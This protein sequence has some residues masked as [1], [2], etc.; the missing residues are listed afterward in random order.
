MTD[1]TPWSL[2]TLGTPSPFEMAMMLLSLLSVIIVLVMTFGRL[3]S[4]TYRLLF[5][6]DTSICMI[7]MINF[8]IGLVRARDKRFFIRHHWIDFIASIPAIEALRMARL[9]QILRVIRLIRM[10]RSL[11][12]PLI[13][14]R[15]QATLASLL[16]AMVTILT[17][18]SVIILIV[19]SGT[20]GAN[21]QTAEQAIWWALVTISTVGY[22]DYYP[23]TTA[24]HI[25]GGIVIVSGVSFFGV[26]S[27]YM[28]SVFVAPDETERQERQEAHKAE[29]KSELELALARMEENQ[30]KMEQNQAQMLAKI[31]ELKQVIETRNN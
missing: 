2:R 19:E 13:K 29:I 15:K 14:Q 1:K 30:Q 6:V 21:I 25:I 4:E 8:F 26:I 9:F 23:V 12:L 17:L 28:A 10:S 5:F 24:G 31:A 16:V 22:G 20:E 18:A 3:D 7:F 11:L 27:G